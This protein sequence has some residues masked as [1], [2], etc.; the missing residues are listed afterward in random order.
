MVAE[1]DR[2][3]IEGVGGFEIIDIWLKTTRFPP[4]TQNLEFESLTFL[5]F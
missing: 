5:N 3:N 4:F 2:D 1:F